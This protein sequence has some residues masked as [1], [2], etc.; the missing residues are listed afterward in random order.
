MATT[1]PHSKGEGTN[2]SAGSPR[3]Q[4]APHPRFEWGLLLVTI[5]S[6]KNLLD[7]NSRPDLI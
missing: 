6:P 5:L 7:L 1:R 4:P 2:S 3:F